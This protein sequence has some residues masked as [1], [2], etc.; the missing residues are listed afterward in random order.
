MATSLLAGCVL[1]IVAM[2]PSGVLSLQKAQN[3]QAAT[4]YGLE[5]MEVTR[6]QF[7]PTALDFKANLNGQ[8][9]HVQ[10][11][12]YP[13][14]SASPLYDVAVTVSWDGQPVPVVLSTRLYRPNAGGH[15]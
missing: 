10:R 1:V 8:S 3:I 2:L 9:F 7:T 4:A 12:V 5:V 15:S 14:P 13:V 6:T 11:A